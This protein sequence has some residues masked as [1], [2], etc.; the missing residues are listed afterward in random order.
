MI[1]AINA[2]LLLMTVAVTAPAN[3]N[4]SDGRNAGIDPDRQTNRV[5]PPV[6]NEK[7]EYY[8]VCGCCEKDVVCDLKKKCIPG[9]DGNKY[10]SI[11]NWKVKWDYDR[12]RTRGVCMPD[13]FIVT[14]DITFHLPKLVH[15]AD[16]PPSLREKWE[17]YLEK[18]MTHEKGHRDRAV[19][20]AENLTQTIA[21]LSPFR[22]CSE[23][24]R[25]VNAVSRTRM[26]ALIKEQ[27]AYDTET[28]H[29]ALQGVAFP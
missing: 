24:D 10:D 28:N 11:T 9:A 29:G 16:T 7:Y 21:G 14:V 27:T 12:K 18:L 4:R 20:A 19:A 5:A 1:K 26:D 22:A 3:E 15:T 23:L 2:F 6:V 8:E 25:T 17:R 13:S